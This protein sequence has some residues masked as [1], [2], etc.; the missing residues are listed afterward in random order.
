MKKTLIALATV[1]AFGSTAAIA[2]QQGQAAQQMAQQ[3]AQQKIKGMLVK[4]VTAME[5]VQA[6]TE[7]YRE[8][9]KT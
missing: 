2:Q 1:M 3:Q 7:K 9:F 6:V 4:F 8:K 5:D